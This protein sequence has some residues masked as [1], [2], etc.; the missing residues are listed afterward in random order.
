MV[1]FNSRLIGF[2]VVLLFIGCESLAVPNLNCFLCKMGLTVHRLVL[3]FAM[4]HVED[5]W[6]RCIPFIVFFGLHHNFKKKKNVVQA[7]NVLFS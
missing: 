7:P 3:G 1:K 2:K 4:R 6:T 5:L